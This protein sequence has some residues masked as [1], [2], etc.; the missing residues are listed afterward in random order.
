M[1]SFWFDR[2]SKTSP[3]VNSAN[4]KSSYCATRATLYR[5]EP[6]GTAVA[7]QRDAEMVR[8]DRDP[9]F[10]C[11]ITQDFVRDG[12]LATYLYSLQSGV[13]QPHRRC[14]LA[15]SGAA[16]LTGRRRN[17][18][19]A[20]SHPLLGCNRSPTKSCQHPF[21]DFQL[22]KLVAQLCPSLLVFPIPLI[23]RLQPYSPI[24]KR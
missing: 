20:C 3:L 7:L 19:R 12:A 11:E 18:R 1:P 17:P 21:G 2:H 14:L 9:E 8:P 16:L 10:P 22:L 15:A 13:A 24:N 5:V 4:C 23:T 6:A